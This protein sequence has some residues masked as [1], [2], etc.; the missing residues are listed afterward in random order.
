MEPYWRL[1]DR[2][3]KVGTHSGWEAWNLAGGCVAL[4][5]RWKHRVGAGTIM[6]PY[7]GLCGLGKAVETPHS[8]CRDDHGTLLEVVWPW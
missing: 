3:G 4:V 8:G 6:K 7:W 2:L 1:C 5:R